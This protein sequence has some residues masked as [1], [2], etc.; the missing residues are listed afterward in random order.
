MTEEQTLWNKRS[1]L[2]YTNNYACEPYLELIKKRIIMLATTVLLS[3]I[4]LYLTTS[5]FF[6]LW[7]YAIYKNSREDT[8]FQS[9]SNKGP[10]YMLS[11]T[12]SVLRENPI[13]SDHIKTCIVYISTPK[14]ESINTKEF[15]FP[16]M[17]WLVFEPCRDILGLLV[18]SLTVLEREMWGVSTCYIEGNCFM[19]MNM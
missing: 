19:E 2:I 1:K 14:R 9:Q 5:F 4:E 11:F 6:L 16:K 15:P 12:N 17:A 8:T 18:V 3:C 13:W 10:D 7:T